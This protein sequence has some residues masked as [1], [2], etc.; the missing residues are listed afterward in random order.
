[1]CDLILFNANVV[2]MDPASPRAELVGI[3]GDKIAIVAANEMLGKLREPQTQIIDCE[4]RTLLPGF[5]DAHCH[6]HAYAESLVSLNLSPRK[7]MHSIHDIQDQIRDACRDM[8]LGTWIRGKSFNEFGIKEER[9]L[10]RWD[11]DAAAPM[12]PIRITHRSGHAHILNSLALKLVGVSAETGDPPDG[13]IDRDPGTGEPTGI[14]YGMGAYLAGKIPPLDDCEINRGFVLLNEKLLSCGITS[15]QD[16]SASNSLQKWRRFE[17]LKAKNTLQPR[18]TVM[19]GY[20]S[21]LDSQHDPFSSSVSNLDLRPAGIKIIADQVTGGLHPSQEELNEIVYN[22]HKAGFQAAIHAVEEPVIEAACNAVEYAL[23][24]HRR[25][26]HRHRIEHCSV[27]PPSFL[28]RLAG[29]GITVVTQPAFIFY[30][31][32]RYLRTVSS[33]QLEHLYA[34]GSMMRSGLPVAFSSDFP[35]SEPNPLMGICAAVTRMTEI[36]DEVLPQERVQV[37]DALRMYTLGAAAAAF[38]E[39]I[40]GTISPEK[41]ADLVVLSEDPFSVNPDAIKNIRVMMTILG[42]RVVWEKLSRK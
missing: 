34:I 24:R 3:R 38:E 37:A 12:N 16:A 35:I 8:P 20:K 13:L 1:M 33:D 18:L 14:L 40:K 17:V 25:E 31:G 10:N 30:E 21:F 22:I 4:G 39:G 42:G 28:R 36:G 23:D 29:L 41:V 9:L 27:C 6:L 26:N 15:V 2:T 11:L 5:I 7:S 32:D 19:A